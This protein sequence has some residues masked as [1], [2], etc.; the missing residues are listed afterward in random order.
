MCGCDKKPCKDL[1]LFDQVGN[2]LT[3]NSIELIN[4]IKQN[5]DTQRF[6]GKYILN[7][8]VCEIL[9][10]YTDAEITEF[11]NGAQNE[12]FLEVKS[13]MDKHAIILGYKF[14]IKVNNKQLIPIDRVKDWIYD[15]CEVTCAPFYGFTIPYEMCFELC[16]AELCAESEGC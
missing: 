3:E 11:N 9:P 16:Y 6:L 12:L 13:I 10:K 4:K 5:K 15:Q 2:W 7:K 8:V 1:N 14:L